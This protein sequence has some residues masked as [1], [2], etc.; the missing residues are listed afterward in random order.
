MPKQKFTDEILTAAIEG[1]EAQKG[2]LDAQ[3]AALRQVLNG[4]RMEPAAP[5]LPPKRRR[6]MSRAARAR[7]AAAQRKRWAASKK[8][9]G[10]TSKVAPEPTRKTRR[11]SA[12]GRRAIVEATKRRWA[13]VRAQA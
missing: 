8:Q 13:K 9:S 2:R 4:N 3:I 11:L 6:K 12:A 7:I 1:Y 10:P 5:A